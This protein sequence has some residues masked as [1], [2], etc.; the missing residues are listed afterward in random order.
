VESSDADTK[1]RFARL[2]FYEISSSVEIEVENQNKNGTPATYH[3]VLDSVWREWIEW[4][5]RQRLRAACFMFDSHQK[6]CYEQRRCQARATAENTFIKVPCP[7]SLWTAATSQQWFEVIQTLDCT[8]VRLKHPEDMS[9]AEISSL[10]L[11]AQADA[12]GI[13][14]ELLPSRDKA[15]LSTLGHCTNAR[16]IKTLTTLFPQFIHTHGYLALYHT[17]L[18]QLLSLT[19]NTW[20]FGQKLTSHSDI[21][22]IFPAVRVWASSPAAAQATWHA[23]HLLRH[24]LKPVSDV[25]KPFRGV[26]EYWFL[27]TSTL[28]VWAFGY[29]P[30][31]HSTSVSSSASISRRASS[32][33]LASEDPAD[34]KS[35]ALA[36]TEAMID[37]KPEQLINSQLRTETGPVID[38]ARLRLQEEAV[39]SH[40]RSGMLLDACGVLDRIREGRK[41]FQ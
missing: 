3:K 34:V 6:F 32:V 9:A 8:A 14:F 28:I 7:K 33:T 22:A 1:H 35:I 25:D 23:C 30:S 17:P 31:S 5:V 29:R 21:D 36:W 39:M 20:L 18:H 24:T 11:S 40:G 15:P 16:L 19:G 2:N 37:L 13:V 26:S 38:A 41:W 10:P 27:Y 4:E 12:G